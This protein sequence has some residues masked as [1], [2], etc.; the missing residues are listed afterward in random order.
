MSLSGLCFVGGGGGR[1]GSENVGYPKKL[2][3]LRPPLA[4]IFLSI[5][6]MWYG[7]WQ[8]GLGGMD[9][10]LWLL[11]LCPTAQWTATD[12][13]ASKGVDGSGCAQVRVSL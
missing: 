7:T 10:Y 8:G 2:L 1:W 3:G 9:P 13:I 5:C 6:L 11:R 12:I 4:V